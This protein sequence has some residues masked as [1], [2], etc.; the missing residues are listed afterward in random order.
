MKI[1]NN[2]VMVEKVVDP[3]VEGEFKVVEV[4]DNFVYKG[5]VKMKPDSQPIY[6]GD[7]P[8]A[9]G[10]VVW[11]AKYSPDTMEL[12]VEGVKVKLVAVKDLLL[13]DK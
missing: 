2:Y 10:D 8:I 6:L 1:S 7:T 11:F 4:Q 12:E 5:R 13:L 3:I 9:V